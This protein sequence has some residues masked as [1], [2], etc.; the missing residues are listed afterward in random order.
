VTGF[1]DGFPADR[2]AYLQAYG[3]VAD[4]WV[5]VLQHSPVTVIRLEHTELALESELAIG[6]QVAQIRKEDLNENC[7]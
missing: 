3:L 6:I 4:D 1:L 5:T 7:R 2:K